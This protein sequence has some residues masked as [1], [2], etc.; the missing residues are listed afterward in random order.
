MQYVKEKA[1]LSILL[2][3]R[4]EGI[5]VEIMLKIL[6]VVIE[7][8]HEILVIYDSKDD[9]CIATV[10]RLRPRFSNV[11][12]VYNSL[13][14]GVANAIRSGVNRAKGKYI[15]IFAV[16]EV[17]PAL[18]I[19]EMLELMDEGCDLVSC[20]RYAYGGRRLGGSFIGGLLS[21]AG[22]RI[23]RLMSGSVLTDSTTGIKM[24]RKSIFNTIRL[25]ASPVGW[26]VVFEL[27]IKAQAAGMK[28]GEVPIV[29]IDRL[30][31]GSSTF[32]LGPWFKEY[33]K[34]F[35]WGIK[36]MKRTG[37]KKTIVRIPKSTAR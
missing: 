5:N 31:G 15:L 30:Y 29:S 26:A 34:W 22:N 35:F 9:D 6:S 32:S 7:V 20:T 33:L 12:L 25:E 3:V 21:R 24:F 1:K 16:D 10:S 36:N 28:L 17:G 2:P 19:E 14:R 4:N 18:A 8:P 23:F 11:N 37:I 27:A 13:G